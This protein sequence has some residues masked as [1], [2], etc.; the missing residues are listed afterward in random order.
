MYFWFNKSMQAKKI[1]HTRWLWCMRHLEGLG[2]GENDLL[3]YPGDP[4]I[5][6]GLFVLRKTKTIAICLTFQSSP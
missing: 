4:N 5:F 2:V 6:L 1:L 3:P